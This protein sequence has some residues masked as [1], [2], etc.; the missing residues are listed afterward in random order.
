M[1][2][3]MTGFIF[4]M[5]ACFSALSALMWCLILPWG[6]G[7]SHCNLLDKYLIRMLLNRV[8]FTWENVSWVSVQLRRLLFSQ[9]REVVPA[10]SV[11]KYVIRCLK[12]LGYLEVTLYLFLRNSPIATFIPLSH[13]DEERQMMVLTM[14]LREAKPYSGVTIQLNQ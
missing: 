5:P 11:L 1:E 6:V 7:W 4:L 12:H 8:L 3:S 2:K 14:Q 13:W 10:G 9:E